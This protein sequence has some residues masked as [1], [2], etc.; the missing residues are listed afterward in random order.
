M[1]SPIAL[2]RLAVFARG[3]EA[4][5]PGLSA[6]EFAQALYQANL[7]AWLAC[8]P[9]RISELDGPS[10]DPGEAVALP[11]PAFDPMALI[12]TARDLLYNTGLGAD[13]PLTTA[14]NKTMQSAAGRLQAGAR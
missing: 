14:L 6:E 2:A 1:L 8:Y 10:V 13:D 9:N 4:L 11:V 7:E 12:R 3:C 5:P